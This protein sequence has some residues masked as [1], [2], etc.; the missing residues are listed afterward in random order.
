MLSTMTHFIPEYTRVLSAPSRAES[1][2]TG[3]VRYTS[4]LMKQQ[5][6]SER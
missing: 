5:R 1:I 3:S 2:N 6:Y 4:R